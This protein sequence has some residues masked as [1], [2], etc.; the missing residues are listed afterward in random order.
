MP[1]SIDSF[2]FLMIIGLAIIMT[3]VLAWL[4]YSSS[5][6]KK[7]VFQKI[8][9]DLA[10]EKSTNQI[11]AQKL[12]D[13]DMRLQFLNEHYEK[14]KEINSQ[15]Q[16][17]LNKNQ[18]QIISLNKDL[19]TLSADNRSLY[20]KLDEQMK[21]FK[22]MKSNSQLEFK[23]L[24]NQL[25]DEK[26]KKFEEEQ[27]KGLNEILS[28]LKEKIKTFEEKIESSDKESIAR[29]S[30]LK[31]QISGLRDLNEK[32]STEANNLTKALKQDSKIQGS[33]GELILESILDKSGLQKNR[34]Y[35][36]QSSLRNSD[37]N[38][39]R[40]D[41]VID[42]PD[43]K[44]IIIDSKVSLKA[45]E[46]FINADN[47]NEMMQAAKDNSNS[48]KKHIDGLSVKNYQDLYEIGSPDFVLMFVPIETAFGSAL[49]QNAD[50][51]GYAFEKNIVI[52]TPST[53]L[54]TL[55]T[56]DSLW[57]N[58]KQ[59]RNAIEIASEAGKMYDKFAAFLI[60]MEAIGKRIQQTQSAFDEGMKKLKTGT[61]NLVTRAEKVKNLGAKAHKHLPQ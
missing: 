39:Q 9:G 18:D 10:L 2:T 36:I 27:K 8:Q 55:K 14:E 41:V 35:F 47:D 28:P 53:L 6:V 12:K 23:N 33:W 19:A 24:A 5:R 1:S 38:L 15:Q 11:Q 20:D 26:S 13:L 48:I 40:P 34:E 16:T 21:V 17:A 60:D 58:E 29:H 50:L 32:M 49:K 3:W 42:L 31:E 54:A 30:S 37:G 4:F 7:N 22:E 46:R 59:Q 25:L 45:Y 56:V 43:N 61:G 57:R 44:K 52:V 51:Y